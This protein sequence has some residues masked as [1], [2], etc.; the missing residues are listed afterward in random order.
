MKGKSFSRKTL[1]T[2]HPKVI[3]SISNL[4]QLINKSR[5]NNKTFLFYV[6]GN[7]KEGMSG[8]ALKIAEQFNLKN[9]KVVKA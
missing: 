3:R 1:T 9:S 2:A 6:R 4:C 5:R 8:N 7:S